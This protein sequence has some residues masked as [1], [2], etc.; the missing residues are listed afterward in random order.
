[1]MESHSGNASD[2]KILYESVKRM[3]KFCKGLSEL[4]DFMYVADSAM[5][6]F[7]VN[8][9]ADFIWMSRVPESTS[10]AKTWLQKRGQ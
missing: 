4:L 5:Y 1:M 2:Q 8:N 7:C 9:S 3:Q 10:E 6:N